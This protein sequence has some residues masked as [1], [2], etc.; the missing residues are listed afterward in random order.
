MDGQGILYNAD[1]SIAQK[2]RW[3]NDKYVGE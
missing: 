3:K 1:G 2:G